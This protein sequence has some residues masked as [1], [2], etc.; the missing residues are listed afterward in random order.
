MD[1]QRPFRIPIFFHHLLLRL[2]GI[3]L[4]IH[5]EPSQASPVL[6]VAN[7]TSYLDVPVLG[8]LLSAGFVAKAEV[9]DWPLFGILSKIQNS[10]FIE[11]RTTRAVEHRL[12]LQDYLAKG[13]NLIL[14]PEGTSSDGLTALPFK[15]SLFSLAEE[16]LGDKTLTVQPVSITC[17]DMDGFP[18][19]REER[20]EYAWYGDMILVPHLWG[21]FQHS[22]FA[23]EVM[24]HAP[25]TTSDYPHRKD[26]ATACQEVVA[27]GIKQSLA[28]RGSAS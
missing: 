15:S 17:V 22:S 24:F 20:A 21:V 10:V 2:L 5:G 18:M 14:F 13:Q 8:S 19:L 16:S 6:F 26:L 12:Q 7:H 9:A 1:P 11:R 28:R 23:V 3:S 4:H 27:E 25:L